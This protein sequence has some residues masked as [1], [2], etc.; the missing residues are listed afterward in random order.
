MGWTA[1]FGLFLLCFYQELIATAVA[2]MAAALGLGF[3]P[4][5][6]AA[7]AALVVIAAA[8]ACRSEVRR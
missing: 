7:F 1:A 3:W 6:A 5:F 2:L 8:A 4:C